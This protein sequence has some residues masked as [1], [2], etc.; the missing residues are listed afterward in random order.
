MKRIS[1][2][3]SYL[4][5]YRFMVLLT[6]YIGDR[7]GRR[8]MVRILTIMLFLIPCFTQ[9]FLQFVPMSINTK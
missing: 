7:I 2:K 4:I 1:I 6:G 9:I 3:Y 8:K 5:K